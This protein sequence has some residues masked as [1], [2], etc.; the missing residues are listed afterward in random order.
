M[1]TLNDKSLHPSSKMW[2]QRKETTTAEGYV[3]L[4]GP[5]I[6]PSQLRPQILR[7]ASSEGWSTRDLLHDLVT[8]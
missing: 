5:P 4:T 6:P 3:Y 2:R 8:E 7:N 1:Y